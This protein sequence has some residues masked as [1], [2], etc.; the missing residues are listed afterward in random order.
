MRTDRHKELLREYTLLS[1]RMR[2]SPHVSDEEWARWTQLCGYVHPWA[3][4]EKWH[5]PNE[6]LSH[7]ATAI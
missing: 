7:V 1:R 3:R 5:N 6:E 2:Y 4:N